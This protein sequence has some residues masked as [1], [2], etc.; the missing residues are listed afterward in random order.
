MVVDPE[1]GWRM[2]R[3]RCAN[4]ACGWQGLLP[5]QSRRDLQRQEAGPSALS[6]L[7]IGPGVAH[8]RSWARA[9]SVVLVMA[10]LALVGVQGGRHLLGAQLAPVSAAVPP[11]ESHDGDPLPARHP[12]VRPV[13]HPASGATATAQYVPAGSVDGGGG[14]AGGRAAHP[15]GQ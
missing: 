5:R 13:A 12:W 10:L 1:T 6:R 14:V 4:L 7:P 3:Y 15:A 8:K 9:G 11:G 2:G